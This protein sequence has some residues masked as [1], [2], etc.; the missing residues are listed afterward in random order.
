MPT[1][2]TDLARLIVEAVKQTLD[3][4]EER[5]SAQGFKSALTRESEVRVTFDRVSDA[6]LVQVRLDATSAFQMGHDIPLL[7][8]RRRGVFGVCAIVRDLEGLYLTVNRRG[9]PEDRC[10]PGGHVEPGET[11]GEAAMR[12][13]REETGIIPTSATLVFEGDDGAGNLAQAFRVGTIP[14][15]FTKPERG[16]TVRWVTR[17]RL[18]DPRNTF[19]AYYRAMFAAFDAEKGCDK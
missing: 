8:A 13:L 2:D 11:P 17:E 9:N 10:L 12:E 18:L 5:Q 19:A 15:F 6:I 14:G 4:Y 3:T 7:R 16:M 1:V